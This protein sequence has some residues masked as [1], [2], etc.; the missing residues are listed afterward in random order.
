M[1]TISCVAKQN[2]ASERTRSHL[3]LV[4][5]ANSC[6]PTLRFVP[7]RDYLCT[8]ICFIFGLFYFPNFLFYFG[9]FSFP[10]FY[11]GSNY[12]FCYMHSVVYSSFLRSLLPAT[13][14]KS[15]VFHFPTWNEKYNHNK[16]I[17]RYVWNPGP[18]RRENIIRS[19]PIR[20]G[21]TKY[22]ME[23]HYA[24]KFQHLLSERLRLSA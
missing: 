8:V 5:S 17:E 18:L 22:W 12:Q 7:E 20:I 13:S 11:T 24:T 14:L 21:C 10:N 15:C 1:G 4:D 19:D 3:S 9:L 23:L 16:L 2:T 6:I